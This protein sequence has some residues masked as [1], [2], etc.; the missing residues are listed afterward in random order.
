MRH[1][2]KDVRTGITPFKTSMGLVWA[3]FCAF[4]LSVKLLS[5]I[6]PLHE[7]TLQSALVIQSDRAQ[8]ALNALADLDDTAAQLG[9]SGSFEGA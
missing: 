9:R 1:A 4:R 7:H 6:Q 5:V 3:R 8:G 2:A